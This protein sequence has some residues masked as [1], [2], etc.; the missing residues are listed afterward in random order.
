MSSERQKETKK[1]KSLDGKLAY[2][3]RASVWKDVERPL[4]KDTEFGSGL[5]IVRILRSQSGIQAATKSAL[6]EG[7]WKG[8]FSLVKEKHPM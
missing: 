8:I 5:K 6:E 4:T 7:P 1:K 2:P 3:E